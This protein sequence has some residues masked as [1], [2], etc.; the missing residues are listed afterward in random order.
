MAQQGL[1]YS[2]NKDED[3]ALS[4]A[5]KKLRTEFLSKDNQAFLF[6]N[7]KNLVDPNISY[8]RVVDFMYEIFTMSL[9]KDPQS[10]QFLNNLCINEIRRKI[11]LNT[12]ATVRV[13][14]RGIKRANI[15]EN[16]LPRPSFS[17]QEDSHDKI[18]EFPM[19]RR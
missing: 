1:N 8:G 14:D 13:R 4:P 18:L 7:T 15:P 19:F 16:F 2:L 3:F 17:R 12:K 5:E 6:T 11:K 10:V 9:S